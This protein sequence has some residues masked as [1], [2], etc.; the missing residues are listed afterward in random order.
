MAQTAAPT[1]YLTNTQAIIRSQVAQQPQIPDLVVPNQPSMGRP[2]FNQ[3]LP[4]SSYTTTTKIDENLVE[5][6]EE[7]LTQTREPDDAR[8]TL[9]NS[10]ANFLN[11]TSN[12]NETATIRQ[13]YQA[14]PSSGVMFVSAPQMHQSGYQITSI[15]TFQLLQQPTEAQ[16]FVTW[17]SAIPPV[18]PTGYLTQTP[19]QMTFQ[20]TPPL[21]LSS[22]G[23]PPNG[24]A[25]TFRP[26][27]M[28]PSPVP[29]PVIQPTYQ[30]PINYQPSYAPPINFSSIP[31]SSNSNYPPTSFS[32]RPAAFDYSGTR[33]PGQ[34]QFS[35]YQPSNKMT[36]IPTAQNQQRLN[37]AR[38]TE[39]FDAASTNRALTNEAEIQFVKETFKQG[40]YYEG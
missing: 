39:S 4:V 2:Q 32:S 34:T 27:S 26:A 35:N 3:Q 10:Q 19:P 30:A 6:D 22:G 36:D 23:M 33:I 17:Q 13:T 5:I 15:P 25:G 21:N 31:T 37:N 14:A 7:D 28:V 24:L 8:E 16:K 38:F 29:V 11:Q 18:A 40:S 9:P 12:F 1:H 20:S